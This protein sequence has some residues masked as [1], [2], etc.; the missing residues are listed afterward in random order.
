MVGMG[1]GLPIMTKAAQVDSQ[2]R[3]LLI[4]FVA[5]GRVT[6]KMI[7]IFQIYQSTGSQKKRECQL[8]ALFE[9]DDGTS[10]M[11]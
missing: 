1:A 10:V 5:R 7:M 9:E 6:F 8:E 4:V 11:G 2:I 3:W